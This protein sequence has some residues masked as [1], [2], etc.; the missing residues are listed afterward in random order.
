M[1][2]YRLDSGGSAIDRRRKVTFRFDGRAIDGFEGDTLASALLAAGHTTIARSFKYHRPRGVF[3]AGPEE[4]SA[5]VTVGRGARTTPNMKAGMVEIHDDLD[6]R[7]QNAWPSVKFDMMA[8][9]QLPGPLFAAGFYY[10][11]FMGPTKRSW[12]WFEPIIRRAAGLGAGTHERDPDRYE[13]L[14]AFCDVLVVG[15]GPAG[16]MAARTAAATGA[17]VILCDEQTEFGGQL[18]SD[19]QEIGGKPATEWAGDTL[20]GLEAKANVTLLSRTAVYGYY[21][22][23]TLGAVE[24]VTDHRMSADEATPRERHWTIRAKSVVIAAGTIERPFVFEYNDTPGIM[25][26][27]AARQFALRH[28]V[29]PGKRVAVFTNNDSGWKAARYMAGAGV[30]I[31]AVI[32][33]RLD[34]PSDAEALKAGGTDILT[35]HVVAKAKGTTALKGVEVVAYAGLSGNLSGAP[36]ALS[37]DCLA[38][39]AGHQPTLHLASQAG[40]RPV[41]NDDIQAF[42]PNETST[43]GGRAYWT[44]GSVNGAY[45]LADCLSEGE[46][47]GRAAVKAAGFSIRKG[48]VPSAPKRNEA[49]IY[50]MWEV[51][52]LVEP[53]K[54]FVDLQ[55][56]VTAEDVRLAEREGYVS[57]EHL[58]RYTTLGMAGDQGKTSNVNGLAIMAAARGV[59][60]QDVG[61]TRFRP[62]Y[63]PVTLGAIAGREVGHHFRPLRR[64][65]MHDWHIAHGG[66][67]MN[68]GQWQRPR[69]YAAEPD[70][71]LEDAYARETGAVRDSVGMTDVSTLG[72]IDVQGPDAA[73][74]LN[75]VYTNGFAKLPVGKARYG[76][77]L[78]DDGFVFD[79]GTTWR[80]SEHQ[81][82]MTTTTANA[83]P[84]MSRLEFLLATA[85][86]DLKV[87][88]TSVTEQWAGMAVSGPNARKVL[89]TALDDIDM[90]NEAFPF[91]GVRKGSCG[92]VPVRVARLSFSG[93]LAYEVYAGAHHGLFVWEKLMAAGRRWSIIPYGMEALGALRIE[94]GHVAGSELD[95][96]TTV[97]DLALRGMVSTK[98]DF[99]GKALMERPD[100]TDPNRERLVG[101]V[102]L[103]DK[104]IRN[105]SHVVAGEKA[106]DPGKSQGHVT[107]NTYSP[108]LG[109]YI[110]LALV[111]RGPERIGERLY[112]TFPLKNLHVPV[113]IVSHHFYDPDGSRMHV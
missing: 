48:R 4:P 39:S 80:L 105:G 13:K 43:I 6:A 17:R 41:F 97:D 79:D 46:A 66:K 49:P 35:A 106:Y 75:R 77:M 19:P 57:V 14:N 38:V 95:G 10:K 65:A 2:G 72:K 5:L 61:T 26:A 24:R 56:D 28:G 111:E 1:V 86:P 32:D 112:A 42:V 104:P 34:A 91:M 69:Y 98:K 101:L 37:V 36:R 8:V 15:G 85:W 92:G 109:K 59:D 81:F 96:R 84:V 44:A 51:P 64:T 94:K 76:I 22:N 12:M 16:L 78:R 107:A 18:L 71:T 27:S 83:G 50:P 40:D 30:N 88:L 108:A 9:N 63:Q 21:D 82:L 29:A 52:A 73:E 58:K 99:I 103:D 70:E 33:P 68:V 60:I 45:E 102:S 7:S 53:A 54:K 11:T 31:V 87:S 47:A 74:L 89:E 110:A 62:P 100:L 93:E 113:E 25:L 23:N 55:H 67:M 90:S 3:A 20:L